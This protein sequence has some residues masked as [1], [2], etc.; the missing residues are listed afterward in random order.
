MS[1]V[2]GFGLGAGGRGFEFGVWGLGF[3][4]MVL[5]VGVWGFGLRSLNLCR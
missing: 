1:G 5:G 3:L 4:V 2:W